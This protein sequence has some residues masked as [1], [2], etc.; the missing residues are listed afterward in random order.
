LSARRPRIEQLVRELEDIPDGE[1]RLMVRATRDDASVST[2][3][4]LSYAAYFA[5]GAMVYSRIEHREKVVQN[6]KKFLSPDLL[7]ELVGNPFRP[8]EPGW[9][10]VG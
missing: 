10:R 9:E 5:D 1:M 7:R 8:K 4:L 2:H 6:F 3:Q